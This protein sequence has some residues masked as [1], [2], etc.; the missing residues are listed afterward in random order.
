MTETEQIMIK[1]PQGI[2]LVCELP[3]TSD[4]S[5][6]QLV[7]YQGKKLFAVHP[8]HEPVIVEQGRGSEMTENK[9]DPKDPKNPTT[10]QD[11]DF[12]CKSCQEW[13][14]FFELNEWSVY[15]KHVEEKEMPIDNARAAVSS[16]LGD[17]IATI[18]LNKD[19]R[20]C[21]VSNEQ[22]NRS[23][24]HEVGHLLL[25]P[26][27]AAGEARWEVRDCDHDW[28]EHRV[29]RKLEHALIKKRPQIPLPEELKPY[30]HFFKEE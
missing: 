24:L 8:E 2:E 17:L 29:I 7:T 20:E 11:F 3:K 12:F 1:N 19:W 16:C 15:Y 27:K 6:W 4:A 13:L 9:K 28:E 25:R 14:D 18:Y 21:Q 23:A 22:L 26:L 5:Q 30:S 10:E